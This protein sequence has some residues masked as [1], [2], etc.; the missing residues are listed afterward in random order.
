M[1]AHVLLRR[2]GWS[3]LLCFVVASTLQS[4]Y[5]QTDTSRVAFEVVLEPVTITARV[6]HLGTREATIGKEA[7][8]RIVEDQGIGLIRRGMALTPDFYLRG[9]KRGEIEVTIDGERFYNACPNR[10]DPPLVRVNPLELMAVAI[11]PSGL[12][13]QSGLGGRVAYQRRPPTQAWSV[14]AMFQ[15]RLAAES[16]FE[17]ALSASGQNHRLSLRWLNP[18]S[19]TTGRGQ[20]F[21][22]LYGYRDAHIRGQWLEGNLEGRQ[23]KLQY[24]GGYFVTR[25]IAFPYLTMDERENQM[26][27]A[28]IAFAGH[29]LYANYSW[30]GMDNGLRAS[31]STMPMETKARTFTIGLTGTAQHTDYELFLSFLEGGKYHGC[32]HVH[33]AKRHSFGSCVFRCHGADV[34]L[35]GPIDERSH[36]ANPRC[37]R[38][39]RAP[40]TVSNAASPC[41]NATLVC[42]V[43]AWHCLSKMNAAFW[44]GLQAELASEAPQVEQLYFGLRRMMG[45]PHWVANPTL[46]QPVRAGLQA[47]SKWQNL[48]LRFYGTHVWNYVYL[49]RRQAYA[50]NWQTYSSVRALLIGGEVR[51][52]LPW[53]SLQTSYTWGENRSH[54][55]PLAEIQPWTIQAKVHTPEQQ[56]LQGWASLMYQ[57]R[58]GRVDATLNETPTPSWYRIDLG[59]RYR[60]RPVEVRLDVHNVLNRTYRQHLSY[61]R[62]PYAAGMAVYEP[63]RMLSLSLVLQH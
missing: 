40:G 57:A 5:G 16:S 13:L 14:T 48:E 22:D 3:V 24:G 50:M 18:R 21:G 38:R 25:D 8:Y 28:F 37:H 62:N 63:G 47:S 53:G 30:H 54:H 52:A 42:T 45:Q 31:A 1:A 58:Q 59:V 41:A 2:L 23:G 29:R 61:L 34:Y 51:L 27:H 17:G 36:W 20:S 32:E 6:L 7:L 60:Y 39:Q 12:A 44:W 9:F 26:G 49:E 4:T 15:S 11:D 35:A 10:M 19:Y 46:A 56:A 33:D 55:T 43:G